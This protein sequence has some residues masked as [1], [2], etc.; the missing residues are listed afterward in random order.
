MYADPQI[1]NP[2]T[3]TSARTHLS[4]HGSKSEIRMFVNVFFLVFPSVNLSFISLL[5]ENRIWSQIV[6]P[7]RRRF[8]TDRKKILKNM[9]SCPCVSKP[10]AVLDFKIHRRTLTVSKYGSFDRRFF[11]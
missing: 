4:E 10:H 6:S 9:L 7:F 1:Q 2:Q 3:C 8:T 11:G 5:M